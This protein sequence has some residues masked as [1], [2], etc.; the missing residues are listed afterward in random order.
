[1]AH[2]P[3]HCL[4]MRK[5]GLVLAAVVVFGCG[6]RTDPFDEGLDVGTLD[7]SSDV[8]AD[9]RVETAHDSALETDFDTGSLD[10]GIA[11]TGVVDTGVADTLPE[12]GEDADATT[13]TVIV[14]TA[15]ASGSL[16]LDR[17]SRADDGVKPDGALDGAFD[18]VVSGPL[19]S[20]VMVSADASGVT[21]CGQQWDTIV[22]STPMP[23]AIGGSFAIGASTWVLGVYEAATMLNKTDGSLTPLGAGTHKLV[24]YGSNSGVFV[25]GQ[26]F[27]VM[28]QQPDGV[29]VKGPVAT[30]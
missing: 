4:E 5:T 24:V 16:T 9:T 6:A 25:K 11:D 17:V 2:D 27:R 14:S 10:T 20:L 26:H 1:V 8:R 23:S 22:G 15:V 29:L 18:V 3:P 13:G 12:T 30:Y 28:G 7:S 19:V 21:C